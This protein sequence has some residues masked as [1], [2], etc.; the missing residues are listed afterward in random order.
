MDLQRARLQARKLWLAVALTG[1][2]SWVDAVGLV[3]ASDVFV[4]FMSGNN[5]QA[6]VA[7]TRLGYAEAGA[8]AIVVGLFLAGVVLGELLSLDG[9]GWRQPRVWLAEAALLW[10]ALLGHW[11]AWESWAWLAL[12]A[13]AMGIHNAGLHPARGAAV[14]T[15]ITG[16]IVQF[17][18]ALA[19]LLRG[20][21]ARGELLA[22]GAAWAGFAAGAVLGGLAAVYL[23]IRIALALPAAFA[24][25]MALA[26]GIALG[27]LRRGAPPA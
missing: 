21:D 23:D 20:R 16:T 19:E 27:R 3:A 13:L 15:Y 10:L 12:L 2:A 17:G 22:N 1:A 11:Q 24:S 8:V 9:T 25:F 4:S 14:R 6:A 26:S 18:R 7:L 5:T